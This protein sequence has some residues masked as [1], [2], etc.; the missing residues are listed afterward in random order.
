MSI[1]EYYRKLKLKYVFDY[2]YF[3]LYCGVYRQ[4]GLKNIRG[5]AKLKFGARKLIKLIIVFLNT[6]PNYL[7]KIF[8]QF[9]IWIGKLF[10]KEHLQLRQI[11][12]G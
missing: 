7:W 5:Y 3:I 4:S 10:R 8:G 6:T 9:Q 2:F 12:I 11:D 1:F